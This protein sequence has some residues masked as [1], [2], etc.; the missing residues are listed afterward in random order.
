MLNKLGNINTNTSNSSVYG[1]DDLSLQTLLSRFYQHINEVIHQTNNTEIRQDKLEIKVN[2]FFDWVLKQGLPIEIKKEIE[3]M[4][5]DGRLADL[6]N[7]VIFTDLN[8][9]IDNSIAISD[10][11]PTSDKNK[12]WLETNIGSNIITINYDTVII[13]N[14]EVSD[15]EIIDKEKLW[16]DL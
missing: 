9:K 5:L 4:F 7:N 10:I 2:E 6:I 8:D 12:I 13:K 11:K 3:K 1:Y 16:F 14:A 15:D